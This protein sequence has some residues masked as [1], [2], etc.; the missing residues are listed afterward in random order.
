LFI[1]YF[2]LFKNVIESSEDILAKYRK[3]PSNSLLN[4]NDKNASQKLGSIKNDEDSVSELNQ[5][6]DLETNS[7]DDAKKKLRLVLSTVDI[8]YV[9]W[10]NETE[11]KPMVNI[12]ISKMY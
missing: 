12:I 6:I 8:Q 1:I 5:S 3:K 9:P 2:Y 7:F 11:S 4:L 10:C